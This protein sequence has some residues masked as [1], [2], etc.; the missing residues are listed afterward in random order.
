MPSQNRDIGG[1]TVV[2]AFNESVAEILQQHYSN[3]KAQSRTWGHKVTPGKRMA[4]S[5][6]RKTGTKG[7]GTTSQMDSH[8]TA[9]KT[10]GS[11]VDTGTRSSGQLDAESDDSSHVEPMDTDDDTPLSKLSVAAAQTRLHQR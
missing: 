9:G 3:Q 6:L 7:T 2:S 11:I 10:S 4:P 5:D 1:E 8:T